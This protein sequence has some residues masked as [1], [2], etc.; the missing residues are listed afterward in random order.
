METREFKPYIILIVL[1]VA[2]SITYALTVSYEIQAVAGVEVKLPPKIDEWKGSELRFCLNPEHRAEF[3]AEE[4]EDQFVCP[5]CGHAL[6][7]MTLEEKN[8]LPD[9]TIILKKRYVHPEK[10]VVMAAVVL[11]GAE[12]SSIHRPEVCLTGQNQKI[13]R[14]RVITV[15][16][17]GRDDLEVMV[18][19]LHRTHRTRDGQAFESQGYYAYWFVGKNRETPHHY[20]RML[21]M[22]LD[23]V[24]SKVAHR[25]AY[26]SVSGL[27]PSH[28]DETYL[29][30]IRS[31]VAD[32]YPK[33]AMN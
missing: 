15:P 31:F 7:G 16:I 20:Q 9:D 24:F 10:K 12:R 17:E 23:S 25:W 1:L 8:L 4:L 22:A 6:S 2:A 18:L 19:D 32:F 11:S 28:D 5:D 30:E 14:N 29:D 21:Y 3:K 33:M 26:I 27:R 13:T